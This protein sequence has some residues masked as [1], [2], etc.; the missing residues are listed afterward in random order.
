MIASVL[1]LCLNL[2]VFGNPTVSPTRE[3]S[4]LGTVSFTG[5][6]LPLEATGVFARLVTLFAFFEGVIVGADVLFIFCVE[7]PRI[8]PGFKFV[9][10]FLIQ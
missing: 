1:Y 4:P 6:Y 9:A 5:L 2:R 8:W 10:V 7:R 3:N